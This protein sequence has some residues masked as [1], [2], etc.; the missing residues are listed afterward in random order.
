MGYLDTNLAPGQTYRYRVFAKDPLGNEAR[1]DTVTVVVATDGAISTYA[2]DV[3]DDQAGQLLAAR[4]ALRHRRDRLGRL[5]RRDRRHRGH[6][7]RR[8]RDHRRQPTPR[9]PSTAPATASRSATAPQV[10]PNTFTAEAWIKTTTTSGGKIVGFGGP[11]TG[12][13]GS[14]DRH[15][16]MANAGQLIFGVYPGGVRT[17]T[18]SQVLQRR[19][20]A[21]RGRRRSAAPACRSTS[22]ASRSAHAPTSPPGQP[23]TGYW[24]IGGDNI[25]GWP[26]QPSS[27]YFTGTIDDVAIYPTALHRGQVRQHYTDSGR[28]LPG[29]TTPAD[30]YGKAV[31]NS[32][33][34]PLLAARRDQRHHRQRRRRRTR[35][36]AP[37]PAA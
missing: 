3:L 15:I 26:S 17:V 8:R 20:V 31:Y 4:R 5:Q 13:S 14:Y 30:A 11:A 25:G 10:G 12:N 33:A 22:T 21:P 1:S 35:S 32:R 24:R 34:G 9:R 2:Q 27:N 6:P 7:R 36:P 19:P 28:T 18:S 29:S 23:Y 16:Y 37:T